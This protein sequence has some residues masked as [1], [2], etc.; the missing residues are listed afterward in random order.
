M[1]NNLAIRESLFVRVLRALKLVDVAPDGTVDHSAGAD[2]IPNNP[3]VPGYDPL[4][5]L[6]AMA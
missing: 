1:A 5:S 3:S 2:F 6:S 4:S